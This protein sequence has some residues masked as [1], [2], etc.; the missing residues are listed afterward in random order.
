MAAAVSAAHYDAAAVSAA[1]Y[2]AAA[3]SAAHYDAAAISAANHE[4]GANIA[5]PLGMK[6]KLSPVSTAVAVLDVRKS[7]NGLAT[8]FEAHVV[9]DGVG[10]W[11]DEIEWD[12]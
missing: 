6:R 5:Q 3:V 8:G 10:A 9:R 2:D 7:D 4:G 12:A 11:L 1:H